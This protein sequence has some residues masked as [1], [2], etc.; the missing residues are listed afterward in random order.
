VLNKVALALCF[1]IRLAHRRTNEGLDM[2]TQPPPHVFSR[3]FS[4]SG[5]IVASTFL[6]CRCMRR[7]CLERACSKASCL[8]SRS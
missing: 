2:A 7:C 1:A 4:G 6:L 5:L 8:A 3:R